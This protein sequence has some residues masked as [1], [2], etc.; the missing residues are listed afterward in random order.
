L[1]LSH[2]Y[3]RSG[4]LNPLGEGDV[5]KHY[6]ILL[7]SV[8][9][10]WPGTMLWAAEVPQDVT[11][12][13]TGN[14]IRVTW[15]RTG[16]SEGYYV[17]WSATSGNLRNRAQVDASTDRYTISGLEWGRT[18]YVAVSSFSAGFES[19]KSLEQSIS[20]TDDTVP[21]GAPTGLT[22]T[23]LSAITGTSAT[24][25][26]NAGSETDLSH[27]NIYY[28]EASG[29]YAAATEAD[30]NANT[31][32]MLTGLDEATRYYIAATAVDESENESDLSDEIIIDTLPDTRPPNVPSGVSG[33]LSG[34]RE[35]TIHIEDSNSATVDFAGHVIHY[36]TATGHYTETLDIGNSMVHVFA[37][38]MEDTTW[39]FTVKAYDASGNQS[40]PSQEVSVEVEDT[41]AFLDKESFDG[42]CFIS[43]AETQAPARR[44]LLL[45]GAASAVILLCNRLNRR[46]TVPR[47]AVCR[48]FSRQ[49]I[50]RA[51]CFL[52]AALVLVGVAP[53]DAN[54][55]EKIR[56][57]LVGVS[58]GWLIPAESEFEDYYGDDT[59]PVFAFFERRFGKFF[60]VGMESG[61]MKKTGERMTVSGEPTDIRTKITLVPVA[62]SVKLYMELFPHIAGFIGAG[63]DYWYCRETSEI[64]VSDRKIEKWVGGWH[65]RTG[66]MLFNLDPGYENTGA[67]ME[68]V[69][70]EMDRFGGNRMDIGGV[71]FRLGFFYGF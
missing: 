20:T 23:A 13:S 14:T 42:G 25:R 10:T 4:L 18:Y 46:R 64:A 48:E 39:F 47:G 7:L 52:M 70:S 71:S 57:N 41:R 62:V 54:A 58:A 28:G 8:F 32:F 1:I 17:Y 34:F 40:D 16:F 60:A 38:V 19:Q 3:F 55:D 56:H 59:Y 45:F 67:V 44:S 43:S 5:M 63:P 31:S 51:A 9:L 6:I 30:R 2:Y 69:Y 26:W 61:F 21:P 12:S 29:N 15:T 35:I 22:V 27:Y 49:F 50:D 11:L 33:R 37:D 65:G 68:A 36:G 66:L 53:A 24:L